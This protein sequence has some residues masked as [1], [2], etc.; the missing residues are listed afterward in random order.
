[1]YESSKLFVD[2]QT[3]VQLIVLEKGSRGKSYFVDLGELG[4][5]DVQ[6]RIFVEQPK[7]FSREFERRTTL[8]NLGYEAVTGSL[9]W[10]QHRGDLLAKHENGSVPLIWAHNISDADQIVL[11]E[12]NSKKPQYIRSDNFL[13]GPAIVVNRITGSVGQGSLR[14]A[15][16]PE[17]LD[18]VGENHV[19]VIRKRE[20][21]KQLVDWNELLDLLRKKEVNT[22][23]QKLTGNTQVSCVELTNFL[24]LDFESD[25]I[26]PTTLF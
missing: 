1:V 3:A 13:T 16:V 5:T 26:E 20:G 24:P 19:N 22:R 8:W 6:R 14:C 7:E 9:V 2:A 23:V 12:G 4:K 15:L 21:V 18:F 25:E 17:G 11:T 10:N